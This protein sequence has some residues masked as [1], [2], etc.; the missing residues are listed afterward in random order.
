MYR[1][2]LCCATGALPS[3]GCD[4]S[5]L[6][7]QRMPNERADRLAEL[8]KSALERG[9][10]SWAALLD[11]ECGT[12][13]AMRAEAE[14]LLEQ[15]KGAS[16]FMEKPALHFVAGIFMP[17]DACVAGQVVGDYEIVSLIA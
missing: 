13:P 1:L 8:V 3:S 10:E 6:V 4:A 5:C 2:R 14:A 17:N 12:D 16:R 15:Q 11:D 7:T 9:P